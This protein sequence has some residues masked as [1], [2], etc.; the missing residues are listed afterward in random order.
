[1]A[2][3]PIWHHLRICQRGKLA[4]S[5]ICISFDLY[6][7]SGN[8]GVVSRNIKTFHND[9]NSPGVACHTIVPFALCRAPRSVRRLIPLCG[10][11]SHSLSKICFHPAYRTPFGPVGTPETEV[12]PYDNISPS[13]EIHH[14]PIRPAH[15]HSLTTGNP[16]DRLWHQGSSCRRA[17]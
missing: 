5:R 7:F 11:L 8:R 15:T 14:D 1:M 10:K 16:G 4:T 3:G 17:S 6:F 2:Q 9:L 13:I 12:I